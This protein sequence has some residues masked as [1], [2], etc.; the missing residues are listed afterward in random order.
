[1][2]QVDIFEAKTR[3]SEICEEVASTHEPVTVTKQGKP[4]VRIDPLEPEMMTIRER[5]EVYMATHGD[6][7]KD[8]AD[9]E[10]PARKTTNS[11]DRLQYVLRAVWP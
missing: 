6:D 3:L 7:E 8:D 11:H 2:K 1:M 5:R 4:L 9:F 10:I